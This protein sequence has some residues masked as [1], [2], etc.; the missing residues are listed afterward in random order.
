MPVSG[1]AVTEARVPPKLWMRATGGAIVVGS[2]AALALMAPTHGLAL[3]LFFLAALAVLNL[4]AAHRAPALLGATAA[5][6]L[7]FSTGIGSIDLPAVVP[8]SAG[9][10]VITVLR[11]ETVVPKLPWDLRA[12][13]AV[14][15]GGLILGMVRGPA[16][17]AGVRVL[18]ILGWLVL[19]GWLS[20]VLSLQR[21]EGALFRA[22][23]AVAAGFG[24]VNVFFFLFPRAEDAYFA[25]WIS[26]VFVEP[27]SI[28]KLLTGDVLNNA[29]SDLKAATVYINANVAAM[30]YGTA[31]WVA[32]GWWHGSR[33]RW[34]LT[35][36]CALGA[37]GTVSRGGALGCA[38]SLL[39]WGLL[40]VRRGAFG[41]SALRIM[42][43]VVLLSIV[44]AA[45]AEVR[46]ESLSRF[47]WS[48]V[49]ADPRFVL[50]GVALSLGQSHPLIG[51]GFGAWESYWPGIARVVDLRPSFPPHNVYLYLWI[52][53]GIVAPLAFLWIALSMLR[54]ARQVALRTGEH[55]PEALAAG[56]M[57]GWCW[58]QANFENF[59]FLDY[60]I[61]FMLAVTFGWLTA[62]R[63]V[64]AAK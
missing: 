19:V 29:L 64:A 38:A 32:Y 47:A 59:F 50:W 39:V 46:S 37:L 45:L 25:S 27:D 1:D 22:Y 20:M 60:R 16:P 6:G 11:R 21:R 14:F 49:S 43:G 9:L 36:A 35:G 4:D 23:A 61:G 7:Y 56:A 18:I 31:A 26:Q 63:A 5:L 3:S 15:L 58:M 42:A 28:R 48:T 40:Q 52:I 62:R 53:G 41:R 33:V 54:A 34:L 10:L 51:S 2:G 44:G 55:A 17:R 30:F 57:V 13:V 24:L 8:I 12:P